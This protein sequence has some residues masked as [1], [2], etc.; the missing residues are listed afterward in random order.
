MKP[1]M[2]WWG[3][4]D[5]AYSR[6]RI[7]RDLLRGRGFE[8]RDFRPRS[9]L[10]GTVESII[11]RPG[12]ADCIWVPCFRHRDFNA[13]RRYA[14]KQRIPL[15]FD[16]LISSWDKVVFE[17]RKY[18]ASQR[19]ARQLLEWERSLFRRSDV[20][21]AD[22]QA[23]RDFFIEELNSPADATFVIP[24]GAEEGLFTA[25]PRQALSDP[26]EI[27]FFGS[28]IHLQGPQV[29]VDAAKLVPQ[30]QWI[31]LG[32]GPLRKACESRGAG[33]LNLHFEDWIAYESLP[34]R[35]GQADI[36]LGVFGESGKAGRVIPNKV[37]QALACGRP[38]VTRA[39]TAY[40]DMLET[41]HP[42]LHF[43]PPADAAALADTVKELVAEP[44]RFEQRQHDARRFFEA[45]FSREHIDASLKTVLD[46]PALQS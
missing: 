33:I 41:A 8:I 35:I 24:V 18:Q 40:P 20:V 17:R 16:P 44:T 11:T 38:V 25:Q 28:F 5:P 13:A 45:Y 4:F 7:L 9:S 29:I 3:R 34:G 39:S 32:R 37:Y 26:P 12:T 30:A 42:G 36:V 43:V 27:L 6:N 31:M 22:T 14:D 23:H 1:V 2:L 19:R 10:F 46:S 15:I 21:I